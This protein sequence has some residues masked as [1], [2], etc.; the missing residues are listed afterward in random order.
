MRR[1]LSALALVLTIVVVSGTPTL[2]N[3]SLTTQASSIRVSVVELSQDYERQFGPR[4][5]AGERRDLREMTRDARREMNTLHRLVRKAER[6]QARRDWRTARNHYDAI[7]ATG[8][9]RL[10]DAQEILAPQ[11]S[12]TEQ[13]RAWAAA[14]E[15][16]QDLDSLGTELSRRAG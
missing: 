8:E 7:R 2:A 11:M 5:S 15:V 3:N 9:A 12:F 16:L 1:A 4:V 6:S 14:R 10:D 13:L